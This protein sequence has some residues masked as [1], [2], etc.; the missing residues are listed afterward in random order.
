MSVSIWCTALR[1]DVSL[2]NLA[3]GARFFWH[4]QGEFYC[5]LFAADVVQVHE[6]PIRARVSLLVGS[7]MLQV[8]EVDY[9]AVRTNNHRTQRCKYSQIRGRSRSR[10]PVVCSGWLEIYLEI[11]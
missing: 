7:R 5:C 10:C 4:H 2:V 6:Y 11:A 3:A 8:R 1:P 9:L